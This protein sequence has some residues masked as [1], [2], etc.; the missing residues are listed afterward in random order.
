[1]PQENSTRLF[2]K[3]LW[4]GITEICAANSLNPDVNADVGYAFQLY[5]VDMLKKANPG[6]ATEAEE[7]VLHSKDLK[8]DIVLDDP[9][10]RFMLIAQCKYLGRS[11]TAKTVSVKEED[12]LDFFKRHAHF[13]DRGWVE[14][15][16]SRQAIEALS[17]YAEN[18]SRGYKIA[19]YF[20][21][22]GAISD[23]TWEA[24]NRVELE[25]A[26]NELDL[27]LVILD[28]EKL[29][30][31]HSRTL[32]L[33]AS[34]PDTVDIQLLPNQYFQV[35]D[36]QLPTIVAVVTGNELKNLY[37]R[38]KERL[39]A[40]NIRGYL[41]D[42]KINK[43]IKVTARDSPTHFYYYNNGISAICTDLTIESGSLHAS[44]FQIINGAQT[45][46]A[47]GL[48]KP[49]PDVRVLLRITKALEV[50]TEKGLN[51]DIIKRL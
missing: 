4:E 13:M 17:D 32:S 34:I 23:R 42:G 38:Y 14:A 19:Y 45:V 40:W 35:S 12:V 27:E 11:K 46:T 26:A 20:I 15:H 24:V 39:F 10:N 5:V 2:R 50:A 29:K 31:F 44:K 47:L 7:A 48:S 25:Y 22:N 51:R 16:G 3:N 37:S 6:L 49:S 36:V 43:D 9:D 28:S 41:G 30:E 8:A 21:T 33:E 1:M 18:V